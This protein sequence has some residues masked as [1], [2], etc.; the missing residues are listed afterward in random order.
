MKHLLLNLIVILFF[1]S[2]SAQNDTS[3]VSLS[4]TGSSLMQ[5]TPP[6][7]NIFPVPVRDGQFTIQSKT[8]ISAVKITNIIGQ[9]IFKSN[10]NTPVKEIKISIDNPGRG[11]YIVM[12][13]FYNNTRVVKKISSEG[14]DL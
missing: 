13:S 12:I 10:Y 5:V 11:I 4:R 1:Q 8:E 7:V 2:L 14:S 3:S 9:E 6:P